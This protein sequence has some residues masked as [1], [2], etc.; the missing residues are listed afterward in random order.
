MFPG[1]VRAVVVECSWCE[2][3]KVVHEQVQ[4][5]A[6]VVFLLVVLVA[7]VLGVVLP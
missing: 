6:V 3:L 2:E 1:V 5:V 4:F 7:Y